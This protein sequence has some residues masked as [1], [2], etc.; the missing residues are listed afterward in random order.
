MPSA[1]SNP[2]ITILDVGH[3]NAAILHENNRIVLF[4][5]G[6]GQHLLRYLKKNNIKDIDALLLSHAD[7]DHMGGARSILLDEELRIKRVFLN[8]DS[9]KKSIAFRQLQYAIREAE[10]ERKTVTETQLTTSLNGR[11]DTDQ[12]KIEVLYPPPYNTMTG[13]GGNSITGRKQT[14]NSLSAAIRLIY[15]GSP[16]LLLGGD[17]EFVCLDEWK[18]TKKDPTADILVFPHHGG[19][20][21]ESQPN[22]VGNFAFE[23]GK[24]VKPKVVIFSIHKER[25]N[26]PRKEIIDALINFI[27][28]IKFIC[29]QVPPEIERIVISEKMSPWNLHRAELEQGAFCKQ[30][31][32]KINLEN[33]GD[34]TFE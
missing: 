16:K 34:I 8:A 23:L 30:G 24:M 1:K 12:V 15:D 26:L 22:D 33:M 10:I 32:I 20:S 27:P 19:L 2:T 21:G 11:L 6:Q 14:S 29:T 7:L 3:G 5:A 28:S 4:D 25:H 31:N 13:V 9:S 18:A 17:I